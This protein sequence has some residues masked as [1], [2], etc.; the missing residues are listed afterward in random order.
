MISSSPITEE[1]ICSWL[2]ETIASVARVEASTLK[3]E[4]AFVDLGLSSLAAVALTTRMSDIFG[5]DVDPMLTWDHPT[6]GEAARALSQRLGRS[7][8]VPDHTQ[9]RVPEPSTDGGDESNGG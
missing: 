6:I 1:S 9:V 8:Q 4:S 3:A 2:I 7:G 5:V